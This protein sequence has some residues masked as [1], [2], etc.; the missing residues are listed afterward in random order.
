MGD[1]VQ[2]DDVNITIFMFG[3]VGGGEGSGG[4]S[5]TADPIMSPLFGLPYQLP[6]NNGFYLLF[7]NKD[8]EERFVV[9]TRVRCID[10][11]YFVKHVCASV[12]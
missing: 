11:E 5:G 2:M 1:T 8:I 4:G 10:D 9:T 12:E 3:S 7:D 6:S